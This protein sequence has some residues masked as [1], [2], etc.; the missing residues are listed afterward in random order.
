MLARFAPARLATLVIGAAVALSAALPAHAAGS[1]QPKVAVPNVAV[2]KVPVPV[3][4]PANIAGCWS[5][6]RPI[7][8]PYAFSFCSN[9]KYG[10]YKV[11]GGGLHCNGS[12]TVT[13]GWGNTATVRLS[14][15]HC[16]G[17]T[18][19]SADYLVCR[20]GG[21]WTGVN[22]PEFGIHAPQARVAVPHVPTQ[23]WRLDCTYHPVAA[24][25]HPIGLA[26]TRN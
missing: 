15:S 9:G 13:S 3:P 21:G 7:Y 2:P 22:P 14:R 4:G 10:S 8:G 24:G 11:R 26:L 6:Q 17:W 16:N 1:A 25:Y 5:A 19:W 18:D 23:G 12:V 20:T